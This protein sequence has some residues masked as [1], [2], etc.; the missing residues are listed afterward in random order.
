MPLNGFD[1]EN[2]KQLR[3]VDYRRK[4][5]EWLDKEATAI[6]RGRTE[7]AQRCHAWAVEWARRANELLNAR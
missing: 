1:R 4:A 5:K 3:V 7:T 6:E 2:R